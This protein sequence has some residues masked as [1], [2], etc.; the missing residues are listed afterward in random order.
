MYQT[1]LIETTML[2]RSDGPVCMTRLAI[3]PAKSSWKNDQFWRT[4]N[5]DHKRG[6]KA[7]IERIHERTPDDFFEQTYEGWYCVGCE[8]FKRENEI[9]DGTC[10]LHPTRT[11]EW[12]QERNWFFRLSRYEDF[13]RNLIHSQET[14]V[15]PAS[16]RNEMLAFIRG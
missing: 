13:L 16:R 8:L 7:L 9:V 1:V 6:V 10:V 4:T 11:L 14:F 3:R 2:S 12:T 5:A 15:Q